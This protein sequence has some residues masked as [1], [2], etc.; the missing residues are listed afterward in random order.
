MREPLRALA[1]QMKHFC[2]VAHTQQRMKK[3]P[4]HEL[5]IVRHIDCQ[6]M[7]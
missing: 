7:A 5:P 2:G 3:S 6:V 1:L 4:E